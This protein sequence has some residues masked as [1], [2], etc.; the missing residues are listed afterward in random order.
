MCSKEVSFRSRVGRLSSFVYDALVLLFCDD[1]VLHAA[2]VLE[3]AGELSRGGLAPIVQG[4]L[5]RAAA[6]LDVGAQPAARSEGLS[7]TVSSSVHY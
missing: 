5:E 1:A 7:L 6:G 3:D 2:H 4:A